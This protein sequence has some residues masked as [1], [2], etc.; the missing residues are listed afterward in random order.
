M[1]VDAESGMTT[2]AKQ[3]FILYYKCVRGS[4]TQM[5]SPTVIVLGSVGRWAT[6]ILAAKSSDTS[7]RP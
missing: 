5:Q 7:S 1:D 4:T 2:P 6:G 3:S